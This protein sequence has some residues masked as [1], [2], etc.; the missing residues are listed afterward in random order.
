M[1]KKVLFSLILAI[2]AT[3]WAGTAQAQTKYEL[4][5]AG[6]QVTSENC[7]DLSVIDGVSGTAKYDDATK[8]L[9]LDNATI[10]NTAEVE[11][12]NNSGIVTGISGLT[13]RLVGNNTI[14]AEKNRGMF[15]RYEKILTIMGEGKLTVK[16]STTASDYSTQVGISNSGTITVSGCTLEVSGGVSGLVNGYW[17]FDRCTVRAKGSGRSNNSDVGSIS[18]L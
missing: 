5:V 2:M 6:T 7:G 14:T 10:H 4:W 8:T 18:A 15:N 9:I 17:K 16:G 11:D 1:K 13:I 12:F 3:M